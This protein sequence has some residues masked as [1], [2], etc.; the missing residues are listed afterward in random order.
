MNTVANTEWTTDGFNY[1]Q[2]NTENVL[3]TAL[4]IVIFPDSS[5]K[6]RITL[7]YYFLDSQEDSLEA[8]ERLVTWNKT[9]DVLVW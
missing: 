1:F 5:S 6:E 3:A 7:G 2:R 8:S 4:S 9:G